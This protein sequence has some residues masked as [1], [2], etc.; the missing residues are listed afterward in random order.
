MFCQICNERYDTK[1]ANK[2]H[3]PQ[4]FCVNNHFFCKN[5]CSFLKD[6]PIC[7]AKQITTLSIQTEVF[8]RAEDIPMIPAND[9]VRISEDPAAIGSYADIFQYK[10]KN[11]QVALKRLR[12]KPDA[13]QMDDIRL[14]AALSC[15]MKHPN[16]VIFFG[17]T[18]LKH[19]YMGLVMEWADQGSLREN[20]GKISN[21]ETIKITLCIC[22]GLDYMH[23]N[24]IVH[25][26]LKPEN[27]LLF[28]DKSTAKIS[29][30]GTS[31]VIKTI[32]T[33]TTGLVGTPKYSA[34]ELMGESLQVNMIFKQ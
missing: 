32:M 7:Q 22:K 16:V 15:K 19:N 17:L 3:H 18:Q 24:K 28:G 14:E 8:Q 23:S 2:Q 29:D 31:K 33:N 6:C 20:M 25:R 26:D 9:L 10:W 27:V 1:P 34:P 4:T 21:R 5:C 11:T 12:F 13:D 30:F